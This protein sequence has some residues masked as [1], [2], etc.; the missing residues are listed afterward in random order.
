MKHHSSEKGQALILIAL[1]V[2][3]LVGF[4]ALTIDGGRVLSDKRNAQNAADTS[5]LTAALAK[6]QGKS[7]YKNYGVTRATSN[8]YTTGSNA[9][10]E[11]NLCNELGVTCQGLPA[12]ANTSEYIRVKITSI[13]PTT[14]ARVLGRDQVTNTVEA[15]ARV[16][17]STS[18]GSLFS[19]AGVVATRSDNSNQCFL[20]NGNADITM[21]NTGIFINCTG[22]EA[23]FVNGSS[24]MILGADATT[25]GCVKNQGGNVSGGN[26]VC[27]APQ[28]TVNASTFANVPTALPTPTCTS[29]GS[30]SGNTLSPGYF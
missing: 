18:T 12:G 30:Q 14:F 2:I 29:P 9:T 6:I 17:G 10:V 28:Q 7:D 22:S 11:I 5:V 4:S 19:G 25:A 26:F 20:L 23:I 15:V 21:H 1:A 8:G 24:N 13:V 16:Q 27:H 3:G